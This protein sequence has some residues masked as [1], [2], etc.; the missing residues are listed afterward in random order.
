MY[1]D[2]KDVKD[3][4]D[5]PRN[6][7]NRLKGPEKDKTKDSGPISDESDEP[8]DPEKSLTPNVVIDKLYKGGRHKGKNNLPEFMHVLIGASANVTSAKETAEVYDVSPIHAHELKHGKTSPVHYHPELKEKINSV[9]DKCRDEALDKLMIS[10]G[11]ITK[12]SMDGI[13]VK[14]AAFIAEKMASIASKLS[15]DGKGGR[16][17]INVLI[18]APRIKDEAEFEVIEVNQ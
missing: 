14:E 5:D 3:R 2:E 6:L 17:N 7:L 8:T 9:T 16:T 10:M 18:Q 11:L 1:L 15:G 13:K 12:K 4:L